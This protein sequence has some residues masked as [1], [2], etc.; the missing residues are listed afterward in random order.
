VY[1]HNSFVFF[2]D[3]CLSV[4]SSSAAGGAP[5]ITSTVFKNV[6]IQLDVEAI[7][8]NNSASRP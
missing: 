2:D 8:T 7:M 6:G 3:C 5:A 4:E 1:Y